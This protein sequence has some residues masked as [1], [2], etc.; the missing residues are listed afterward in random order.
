MSKIRQSLLNFDLFP[1]TVQFSVG[2]DGS[3]VRSF[4]GLL[5]SLYV[6]VVA[7]FYTV[8]RGQALYNRSDTSITSTSKVYSQGVRTDLVVGEPSADTGFVFLA[9]FLLVDPKS[10]KLPEDIDKLGTIKLEHASVSWNVEL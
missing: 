9:I 4:C 6:M 7:I 1:Q 5:V 3:G 10:G 2:H 8:Q